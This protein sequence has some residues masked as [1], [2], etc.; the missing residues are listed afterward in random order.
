MRL[1]SGVLIALG[2]TLAL[3]G[4]SV[5]AAIQLTST[6]VIMNGGDQTVAV[7]A[8]NV[9]SLPFVVQAWL[10]GPNEQ[11][12]T[13]FFVTPPLSRMDGAAERGLNITRVGDGLPNDR[14]SL[15]WLN[16][17]EIPQKN[18]TATNSLNVA[19]RTRIKF[20]YRPVEIK[21][22]LRGAEQLNWE[23]ARNGGKCELVAH[24]VSPYIVNFSRIRVAE[25][26]EDFGLG[27]MAMPFDSLRVALPTCPAG[28]T[29]AVEPLVIN[30]YGAVEAW[31]KSEAGPLAAQTTS[32]SIAEPVHAPK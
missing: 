24:N 13:P 5:Q 31:P 17:L 30:D 16:V 28:A 11:M 23:L 32:S 1:F 29:V 9:T 25:T 21:N 18:Q 26:P 2:A 15:F 22:A 27:L 7:Y 8:R 6:R 19:T 14:E 4:T 10:E 12:D 3:P 20:F